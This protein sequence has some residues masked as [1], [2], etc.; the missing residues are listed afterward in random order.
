MLSFSVGASVVTLCELLDYIVM[1]CMVGCKRRNR[2]DVTSFSNQPTSE[3][4]KKPVTNF[5]MYQ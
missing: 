4:E 5:G 3:T 2:N 1:H